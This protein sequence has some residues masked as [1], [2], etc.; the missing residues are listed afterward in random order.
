MGNS[1][2]CIVQFTHPGAEHRVSS[3]E[4]KAGMKEWNYGPH[5]RKFLKANGNYLDENGKMHEDTL[6]FWG[7]W[8]PESKVAEIVPKPV[9]SSM[10]H[11]VHEPLLVFNAPGSLASPRRSPDKKGRMHIRQN[12]DPC[13]FGNAFYYALCKQLKKEAGTIVK[14]PTVLAG[15]QKGSLILFG[16]VINPNTP[17]AAFLLDTVFVIGDFID[18]TPNNYD[19]DL[20]DFVLDPFPDYESIMGFRAW[21]NKYVTL[22]CYKGATPENPYEGLYSF[23]PCKHYNED[24]AKGFERPILSAGVINCLDISVKPL[25]DNINASPKVTACA[26]TDIEKVW[27]KV[28]DIVCSQGF[29]E[30]VKFDYQVKMATAGTVRASL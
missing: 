15:L 6:L 12:T 10:P 14:K 5:R 21:N 27:A 18:Y 24:N 30:G 17:N 4:K 22:R 20:R 28:R 29:V 9:S 16:S 2:P 23:V 26:L 19:K 1:N 3:K 25:N 11:F 7:E 13:V 8:E